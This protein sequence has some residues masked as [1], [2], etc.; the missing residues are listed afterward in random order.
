MKL[1]GTHQ[2]LVYADYFNIV[3]GS[4]QTIRKN[5]E[6]LVIAS[7]EIALKANAEKSNYMKMSRDHNAGQNGNIQIGNKSFETVEQFKYLGTT[8]TNQNSIHEE[9]KSRLKSRNACYHSVQNLF[10]FQFA[11]RNRTIILLVVLYGCETWTL[12]LREEHRLRVFE[13][14]VL[15]RIFEPKRDEVTRDWRR[16]HNVE[17]HDLYSSQNI[18]W[19]IKL[20]VEREA[21][22]VECMG[23]GFGGES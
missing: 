7:K 18:I 3:G 9:I 5:T 10:V 17:L 14:K 6:A 15:R 16:P 12:A 20:R 8:L 22:H 11:I 2:L 4:I 23:R 19:V 13:N 21:G 1:N